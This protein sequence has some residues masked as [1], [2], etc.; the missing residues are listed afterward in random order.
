MMKPLIVLDGSE[1]GIFANHRHNL[2]AATFRRR[3]RRCT[4]FAK[5]SNASERPASAQTARPTASTLFP[6]DRPKYLSRNRTEQHQAAT[7][8]Q[9]HHCRQPSL[10]HSRSV[11]RASGRLQDISDRV[12][13]RF[14][15]EINDGDGYGTSSCASSGFNPA[16]SRAIS[17]ARAEPTQLVDQAARL[18]RHVR[19]IRARERP[20]PHAPRR[21]CGPR[22]PW[23]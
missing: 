14:N 7:R 23:R 3:A 22:R 13:E 21:I 6:A 17:T 11:R 12:S 9:P 16:F 1:T 18:R 5:S 15:A 10:R 19:S 4:Q 20:P 8:H 2:D